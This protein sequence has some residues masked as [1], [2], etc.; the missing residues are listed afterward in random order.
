MP[1]N[2]FRTRIEAL[3]SR[4]RGTQASPTRRE[5]E[6]LYTYGCA[7]VLEIEA[8]RLRLKRRADE[9]L[10]NSAFDDAAAADAARLAA[11]HRGVTG[12]LEGV[13]TLV[14]HLGTAVEWLS[15]PSGPRVFRRLT[16]RRPASFD[17][18]PSQP[19][20]PARR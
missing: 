20:N 10:A 7:V 14:R 17:A 2:D 1:P 16:G 5:V 13:R 19:T 18:P 8:E 12:E 3:V 11:D 4:Y 15:E 9:A 6:D